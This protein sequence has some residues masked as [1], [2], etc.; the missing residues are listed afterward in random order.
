VL[1]PNGAPYRS[2]DMK[3]AVLSLASRQLVCDPHKIG[4]ALFTRITPEGRK[5][6]DAT[7]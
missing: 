5:A 1:R 6:L 2:E 7:P 3:D 4:N